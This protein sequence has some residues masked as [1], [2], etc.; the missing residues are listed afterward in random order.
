[1]CD[2]YCGI[3]RGVVYSPYSITD[4]EKQ[5]LEE[6]IGKKIGKTVRLDLKIDPEL[7]VGVRVEVEGKVFDGSMKNRIERLKASLKEAR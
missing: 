7:I 4:E 1:M 3:V 2:E 6:T 5:T